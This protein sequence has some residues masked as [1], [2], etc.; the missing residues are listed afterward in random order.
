MEASGKNL[1]TARGATSDDRKE[2]LSDRVS[3]A[4]RKGYRVESQSEYQAVM[5]K[6]KRPNHILHLILTIFTGGLWGVFVWLPL[7]I[8]KHEHRMVLFVDQDG[9]VTAT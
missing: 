2:I 3:A 7:S 5:L 9:H 4:I 8:F 6:G 1:E